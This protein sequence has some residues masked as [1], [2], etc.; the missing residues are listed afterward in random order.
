MRRSCTLCPAVPSSS[1]SSSAISGGST[2]KSFVFNIYASEGQD[3]RELAKEVA[4]EIQN[5]INDKEKAYA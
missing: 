5:L 1:G 3:V 4:K 2:A